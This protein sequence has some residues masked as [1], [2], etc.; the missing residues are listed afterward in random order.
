MRIQLHTILCLVL[1]A[2]I[3]SCSTTSGLPEDE[4]L[5]TGIKS[6]KVDDAKGTDEEAVAMAEV[7]GALAYA[8]N[9]SLFGSS[10]TRF[11]LPVG[12]WVYNYMDGKEVKG[13]KKWFY[14]TFAAT[15]KTVTSAAPDMRA[16]I[17]TN[18]LQNYGYFQGN[19]DYRLIPDKRNPRKQKIA[20]DVHLGNAY[21]FD[22]INYAFEDVQDSVVKAS[23]GQRFIN[24][25]KQFSVVDLQNEKS[26]IVKEFHDN[27][28]YYYRPDYIEYF[29][30]SIN[31]PG[32]VKLL[33]VPGANTPVIAN[34]QWKF[35]RISA[36]IRN[37][38]NIRSTSSAS[39]TATSASAGSQTA[40]G[41]SSATSSSASR[42][43]NASRGIVYDDTI[44][45]RRLTLAYQGKKIPVKSRIMF[46]NFRFWTGRLY[47]ESKVAQTLK[48][49]RNMNVFSNVQF[50]FTPH[51]TTDTCTV[52]DVRLDATMEKKISAEL[53]FNFTQKSN[54][55][56]GPD[57]SLTF[58]K[59]NAFHNSE[60][61][62]LTLFGSYYWQT[63]GRSKEKVNNLD[64]YEWGTELSL[65]YPWLAMPGFLKR[66]FLYPT[67][68]K[69]SLSFQRSNIA[70][71]CR[72]NRMSFATDYNF[73]TSKYIRHTFTP[74]RVEWQDIRSLSIDSVGNNQLQSVIL[75]LLSDDF[76][77]SMQYSFTYDNSIDDHRFVSTNFMASVK[78]AG[79]IVNGIYHVCGKGYNTLDKHLFGST[80]SQFIKAHVEL[81]NK[82]HITQ[83][84]S[85]AT[86]LLT[87]V[88]K[89][90]GN[91]DFVP[92]SEWYYSGGA[93]SVRAFAPRSIGPGA[94]RYEKG[95]FYLIHGGDFRFEANAELRFPIFGDL[96]G[97]LFVDAGN[98]W[99][100]E[101]VEGD[102]EGV[103]NGRTFFKELALGTGFGFRYDLQ[104][105]VLRL[106]LGV[107]IHAPYDTGKKGYY[108]INR[109]FKDGT[110]I[111][112]AVGYPF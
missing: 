101:S 65:S 75:L 4:Y 105:L 53:D 46:R 106:D 44:N 32:E 43:G 83:N 39:R 45:Y 110:T 24:R 95:D 63:K 82:F 94:V 23:E 103:L 49:L 85:V 14:N 60:T 67:S 50:S 33:V 102:T 1:M 31:S 3:A 68:T 41:T 13:I 109:F 51:D 21:V 99:N 34:R 38:T 28:F 58:S 55:Q 71:A 54:S 79:N 47:N 30:D 29:A 80:F 52:L 18:I 74:L 107:A 22:S 88:Q 96:N 25:G 77:P 112:F 9:N 26:R 48:E 62:A 73:Q 92:I 72:L 98:V 56:I 91:S 100:L 97:A 108:N 19:V 64:T 12:L 2:A 40:T 27:G 35:G 90:Y 7:E 111:N 16:K 66:R 37:S 104:F 15:P 5:Y 70:K 8:P 36:F 81:R 20:Y 93:N 6:I 42:T 11:P 89:A 78:E 69:F 86:R 61:L 87:G 84:V 59:L 17:A 10:T 57:A 76:I